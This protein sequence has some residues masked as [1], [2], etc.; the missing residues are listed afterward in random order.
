MAYVDS[1]T[2]K[3]LDEA[4]A[5]IDACRACE[6]GETRINVVPGAG[7]PTA[8]VMLIGEAP[9]RNED[10][11]GEPFVGAAGKVLDQLLARI[12]LERDEV[13][14]TSILKCRPP[15]NR[16]PKADEIE[17]C[18]PWLERQLEAIG[19][20]ILVTM[21]N[22]ATRFILHTKEPI[23]QLRGKVYDIDTY[24]VIPTYHPAAVIYDRSKTEVLEQDF[25]LIG[26][27]LEGGR[28]AG[29]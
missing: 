18:T 22:F 25:D 8:R 1:S 17:A 26:S 16:N 7:S 10:V 24:K 3:A 20:D 2:L 15:R 29:A 14:I 19:P 6:L 12:G 23:T 28:S 9:G 4:L 27:M 21:G 5:G 13:F 11:K